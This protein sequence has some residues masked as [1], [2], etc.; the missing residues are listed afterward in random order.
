[1]LAS[2]TGPKVDW[3]KARGPRLRIIC[4]ITVLVAI[5]FAAACSAAGQVPRSVLL[6]D[7]G[8]VG[9]PWYDAYSNAFRSAFAG[10]AEEGIAIHAEHLDFGHFS[11]PEHD[12][13]LRAY[14]LGK[15]RNSPINV[16][17]AAG[18]KALEFALHVRGEFGSNV[19]VVFSIVDT[20]TLAR[21][22]PSN[23]TGHILQYTLRDQI[24]SA[25]A[26]VPDL[27][28]VALVGDPLE[29]QSFMDEFRRELPIFSAQ[30]DFIDLTGLSLQDVKRRVADL[31]ENSA[32]VYTAINVDG[33]GV[34]YIPRDAL[35]AIADVANRPIVID[36]ETMLG[37]GGT[38]GFVASPTTLAQQTAQLAL[39]VL[40]GQDPSTIPASIDELKPIFDWRQMQRWGIA[41]SSLPP[42]S[43]IYFREP[44][45]WERYWWQIALTFALVLVQ[46]GLISVLLL[47]HRRRQFAEVHSRQHMAELARVMRFS[48]AGELTASIAHEINQPLGA[49]LTNAET[50]KAILTSPSPDIAELNEIVDDIL[51]DDQR[52]NEVIRR[53]RSLLK[54][55]PFE[56]KNFDLNDLVRETLGVLS[57][58]AVGRKV[59]LNNLITEKALP[60]L[61]DRIQL[62]Q[63]ILN[64]VVNG[65]DAMKDTPSEDRIISI[66]TSRVENFAQLSV[67]DRGHGIPEDKLKEVFAAFFTSKAEG[68]GM[69]LS[70]ARTIIEAHNGLISAKNR[71]HGGATFRIRL[72]LV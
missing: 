24:T 19:P 5:G 3:M 29:A 35:V 31:P 42:G 11:S 13:I 10:S 18:P 12:D 8:F 68:M 45:V 1:M 21:L 16:I 32:I 67:S 61:G 65:I 71:D 38:G 64:L 17:V 44:T 34:S 47:E 30:L 6:L 46:G 2:R 27:Q 72:P 58:L 50:A 25:R 7:Q 57:S 4:S 23:A 41:E 14:V 56:L 22:R 36:A 66:R 43:T 55:A 60:I 49:I 26:L 15:Y 9:S 54:K 48:T 20:A 40:N 51:K 59:E 69:G 62:Q 37:Y 39:R 70:I 33:A 52:A 63:V 53:M 28:H